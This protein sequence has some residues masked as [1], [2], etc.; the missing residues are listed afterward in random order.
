M[1][2]TSSSNT[3]EG[4][5]PQIE[6]DRSTGNGY[7]LVSRLY[8]G[9]QAEVVA[10]KC[11]AEDTLKKGG[12]SKR[13]SKTREGMSPEVLAKS[14]QR[15]KTMV[16]RKCLSMGADRLL[17]LT[18][19]DNVTDL[20]LAQERFKYFTKLMRKRFGSRFVYVA[21]VEYQKR[22]AVHFHLAVSGYYPV[23]AVRPLWLR[24]CGDLG[25]NID[26]TSPKKY[27]NKKSWNPKNIAGYLAKYITK[28]ETTEINKKRYSSG[29]K[30]TIPEAVTGWVAL[31]LPVIPILVAVIKGLTRHSPGRVW[32]SGDRDAIFYLSTQ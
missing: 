9:G 17:T 3:L 2:G 21:V 25:G 27:K 22:G 16:R 19:K 32:E 29:G 6:A 24:A 28:T 15:A 18:F 11:N 10:I 12:G 13:K 20:D 26:I 31:G 7:Y 4:L 30:I 14:C 23:S 8:P 1:I 5:H